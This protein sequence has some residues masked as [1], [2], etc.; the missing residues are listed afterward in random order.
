M[1]VIYPKDARLRNLTYSAHLTSDIT[2]Q[3]ITRDPDGT[4]KDVVENLLPKTF[5][6]RLPVML[7]SQFCHLQDENLGGAGLAQLGECEYDQGGYF[8]IN[9]SEKVVIAQ[10]RT[11][12]QQE[13]RIGILICSPQEL[14]VVIVHEARL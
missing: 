13:Y 8:I 9:G 10:V 11:S 7:K 14:S 1:Q 2:V 4:P 6:G 3:I 5:L 12:G